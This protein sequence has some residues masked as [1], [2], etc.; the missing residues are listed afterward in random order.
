M[1]TR[2]Q[3]AALLGDGRYGCIYV[4]CDGYPSYAL[5]TLQN[6]YTDQSKIDQLIELGDCLSIGPLVENC[7]TFASRDGEELED[8]KASYGD[9]L[10][11]VAEE[12]LHGDEEY[13]YFW[14]GKMWRIADL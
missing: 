4:H 6:H 10:K 14:D 11:A 7:D 2:W 3:I 13:R 8:V 12:H 1:S 9:S 5:K